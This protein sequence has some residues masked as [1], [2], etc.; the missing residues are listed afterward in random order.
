MSTGFTP[1]D[2][3]NDPNFQTGMT[4][5]FIAA[6]ESFDRYFKKWQDVSLNKH[7]L[8][9]AI[10]SAYCDI[11][12]LKFFRNLQQEDV[13]K[14]AAFLMKWIVKFV[15]IQLKD[16]SKRVS[17]AISNEYFAITLAMTVMN[18]EPN[19]LLQNPKFKTYASNLV[20]LLHFH[21]CEPEQLASELFLLENL[22]RE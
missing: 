3:L 5:H 7:L 14:R 16:G 6:V 9:A 21:S 1:Q 8:F 12:R 2:I 13:H 11:Y 17:A 4:A 19:R 15:P 22:I 10:G 20:Y 18:I